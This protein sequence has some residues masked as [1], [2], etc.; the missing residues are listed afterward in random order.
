MR[1]LRIAFAGGGTGGHV[2]PLLAVATE[3]QILAANKRLEIEMRYFGSP[4][5][6]RTTLEENGISVSSIM[7]SKIRRY[8]DLRNLIDIPK[9]GLSL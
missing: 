2:Y 4:K 5:Q 3:T 1:K 8:F 6:Y 9:F 7:E